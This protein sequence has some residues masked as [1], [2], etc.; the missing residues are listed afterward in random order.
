MRTPTTPLHAANRTSAAL[1][2]LVLAA[3][4]SPLSPALAR[5]AETLALDP[6]D[7]LRS[8][9]RAYSRGAFAESVTVNVQGQG[10]SR[11]DSLLFA[12]TDDGRVLVQAGALTLLGSANEV[13]A[14]H[15]L[16]RLGMYRASVPNGDALRTWRENFPPLP[17]PQLALALSKDI[18]GQT[19]TP[20]AG[21]VTW[22]SATLRREP[23]TGEERVSIVGTSERTKVTLVA[24]HDSWR[25]LSCITEIDR[26][27]SVI[28]LT[29]E[30]A[31][32]FDERAMDLGAERR[33]ALD[34]FAELGP[35]RGDVTLGQPMPGL[36]LTRQRGAPVPAALGPGQP[37]V[38]VLFREWERSGVPTGMLEAARE[39][40]QSKPGARV[41]VAA[42]IDFTSPFQNDRLV[43]LSNSMRDV[44]LYTSASAAR[45]IDR[46]TTD[47]D[48]VLVAYDAAGI[49][50]LI[51]ATPRPTA[52]ADAPKGDAPA[53]DAKGL[54]SAIV[55]AI[56]DKAA[57]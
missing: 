14:V 49:I 46:F 24:R 31:S 48:H 41:T 56:S 26:G 6:I 55:K 9:A 29:I 13:A 33:V 16:D 39:A 18:A 57:E 20:Y 23:D 10:V 40:G 53:L 17:L 47:A 21:P 3:L 32:G 1:V 11:G 44:E 54:A 37:G 43:A 12:R 50:R 15:E 5:Q 27:T 2:L 7:A 36:V 30:P 28:R 25:L 35:R 42:I 4:L 34:S 22:T 51:Y 19:L 52:S 8:V 38:L 45:T